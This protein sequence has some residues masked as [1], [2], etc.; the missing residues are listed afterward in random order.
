MAVISMTYEFLTSTDAIRFV[1]RGTSLGL[2][3]TLRYGQVVHVVTSSEDLQEVH[4]LA[5]ILRGQA[6]G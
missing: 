4:H 6:I 5:K 1:Q 2:M 3:A